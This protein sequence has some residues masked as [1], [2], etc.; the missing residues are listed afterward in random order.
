MEKK[1]R[2]EG[3]WQ[4]VRGVGVKQSAQRSEDEGDFE[5]VHEKRRLFLNQSNLQNATSDTKFLLRVYNTLC[6]SFPSIKRT[7]FCWFSH[8]GFQAKFY[9]LW[10][11]IEYSTLDF[12][13]FRLSS[14]DW[15]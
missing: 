1:A 7:H 8:L 9:S 14:I 11:V 12:L 3:Q 5:P 13:L 2:E 15:N 10:G 4:K 6:K